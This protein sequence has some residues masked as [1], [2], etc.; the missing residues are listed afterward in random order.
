MPLG[1]EI[2]VGGIDAEIFGQ[3]AI[4]V[5]RA[6]K[7]AND[8]H[9]FGGR[10]VKDEVLLE[11]ADREETDVA[12]GRVFRLVEAAQTR[13]SGQP[14]ESGLGLEEESARGAEIRLA[15]QKAKDVNKVLARPVAAAD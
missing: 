15:G 5:P 1:L 2:V 4:N 8:I 10:Q 13:H 3:N 9:S 14:L 12:E 11:S 7:D 6:V